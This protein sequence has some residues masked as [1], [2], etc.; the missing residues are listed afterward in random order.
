MQHLSGQ[1]SFKENPKLS[2]PAQK[3]MAAGTGDTP[4]AGGCTQYWDLGTQEDGD[5]SPHPLKGQS[6]RP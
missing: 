6:T 1:K 3:K 2:F 4:A 5:K